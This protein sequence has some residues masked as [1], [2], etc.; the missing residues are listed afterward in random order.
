MKHLSSGSHRITIPSGMN[1][2]CYNLSVA[3]MSSSPVSHVPM[4][5]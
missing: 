3:M 4:M 1:V 5:S 2:D